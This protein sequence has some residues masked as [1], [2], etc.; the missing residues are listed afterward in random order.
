MTMQTPTRVGQ[1]AAPILYL[2]GRMS[3]LPHN[4]FPAF[5]KAAA[6]LR[7]AGYTV[8]N[9][10]EGGLPGDLPWDRYLRVD[11][12]QLVTCDAVATLPGWERSKGARLEVHVARELGMPVRSVPAWLARVVV[13]AGDDGGN[14]DPNDSGSEPLLIDLALLCQAYGW[15]LD[16]P[17]RRR[18]AEKLAVAAICDGLRDLRTTA[19]GQRLRSFD[20]V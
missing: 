17:E 19:A 2:S 14:P 8:I 9:P 11:L 15:P 6:Q 13:P 1:S 10:A 20:P 5:H 7:A 18:R 16:N 4:N 12:A 3:G